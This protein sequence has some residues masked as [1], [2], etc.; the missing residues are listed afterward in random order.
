MILLLIHRSN[1]YLC[2][3]I[4]LLWNLHKRMPQKNRKLLPLV[5]T[6][7]MVTLVLATSVQ[8]HPEM[9]TPPLIRTLVFVIDRDS[10]RQANLPNMVI[11]V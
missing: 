5:R 10:T 9:R 2:H 11:G 8:N 3:N 6:L 7:C 1:H 4:I